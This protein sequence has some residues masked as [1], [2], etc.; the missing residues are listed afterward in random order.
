MR[1][2]GCVVLG[3]CRWARWLSKYWRGIYRDDSSRSYHGGSKVCDSEFERVEWTAE[4]MWTL[5]LYRNDVPQ[6]APLYEPHL[7]PGA[8][9]RFQA[10]E[11]ANRILSELAPMGCCMLVSFFVLVPLKLFRPTNDI[12]G[13]SRGVLAQSNHCVLEISPGDVNRLTYI[14]GR[15]QVVIC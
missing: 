14:G 1:I 10:Q 4:E 5:F 2:C 6:F 7:L 11:S 8:N 3:I 15:R 12:F 13:G 9:A